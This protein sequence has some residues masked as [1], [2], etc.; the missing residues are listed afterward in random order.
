LAQ[1]SE[2]ATINFDNEVAGKLPTSWKA[3]SSTWAIA[4][5]GTNK[6]LKQTGK[7]K[8]DQSNIC[9]QN[10]LRYQNLQ[11]EARIKP[12]EGGKEKGGGLVW[13]YHDAKNY[14]VARVNLVENNLKIYKV[15]KGVRKEIKSVNVKI[16]ANEWQTLKVAMIGYTMNCYLNDKKLL[17]ATDTTLPNAGSVGFW[18][19]ADAVSLFDDLK[20]KNLH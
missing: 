5:D 9:I 3:V 6:T 11:I 13:R 15:T 18:S 19:R 10:K 14:Y 20:I 16:K 7:N 4:A 8:P 1:N 2:D 12:V 17:S